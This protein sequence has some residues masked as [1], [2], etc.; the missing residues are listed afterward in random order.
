MKIFNAL[1]CFIFIV[2]AALQYNDPDP[3]LWMPIYLY[4]ALFCGLAFKKKFYL[5]AYLLGIVIY[6]LYAIFLFFTKDGVLDWFKHHQAQNIAANMQAE[7]P[8]IEQ[9]REFF[10]LV[11]VMAVLFINYLYAKKRIQRIS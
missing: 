1:F 11:I 4:A 10:G 2:F 9:T 3:Y 7:K 5:K 8:W 6:F